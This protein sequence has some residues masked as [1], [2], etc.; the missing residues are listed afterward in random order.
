[1]IIKSTSNTSSRIK[2]YAFINPWHGKPCCTLFSVSHYHGVWDECRQLS[3]NEL[4]LVVMGQLLA[5]MHRGDITQTT[6]TKEQ[7]RSCTCF[8]H[9]GHDICIKTFCFCAYLR[10]VQIWSNQSKL[11]FQWALSLETSLHQALPCLMPH[12][13]RVCCCLSQKLAED[14]AILLPGHISGYKCNDIVHPTQQKT[15]VWQLCRSDL[16]LKC[17]WYEGSWIL[18]QP[19]ESTSPQHSSLQ[20]NVWSGCPVWDMLWSHSQ[21]GKLCDRPA[22]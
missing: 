5:L 3:S 6:Y 12:W 10:L 4:D 21:I 19:V 13:Y 8:K 9:G 2:H 7:K 15:A 17:T 11:L 22:F 14:N 1:M 16:L 20:A 18:L